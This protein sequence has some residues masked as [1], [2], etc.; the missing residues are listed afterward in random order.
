MAYGVSLFSV[1]CDAPMLRD[2]SRLPE[3]LS[4]DGQQSSAQRAYAH[5]F[6]S[7][8]KTQH[9]RLHVAIMITY[10]KSGDPSNLGFAPPP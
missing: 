1:A 6:P 9:P 2:L 8:S 7:Q 3:T 10:L 4:M 5:R